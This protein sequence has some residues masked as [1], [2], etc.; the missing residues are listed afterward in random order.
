M[1]PLFSDQEI[2]DVMTLARANAHTLPECG[3]GK[4]IQMCQ[5]DTIDAVTF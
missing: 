4:Q 5:D 1:S 2:F 3:G